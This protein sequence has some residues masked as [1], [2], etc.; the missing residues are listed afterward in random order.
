MPDDEVFGRS[1]FGDCTDRLRDPAM[2]S[3]DRPT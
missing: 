1:G 2:V 3:V